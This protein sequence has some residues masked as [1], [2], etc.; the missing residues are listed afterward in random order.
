MVAFLLLILRPRLRLNLFFITCLATLLLL[1]L[2]S[3]GI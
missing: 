1:P 2:Y 3:I